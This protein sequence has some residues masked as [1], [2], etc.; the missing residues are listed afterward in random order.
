MFQN[1]KV[2]IIYYKTN[3]DFEMEFNLCG[4]CRMRLLTDKTADKK[5][6]VLSLARAVNRSRIIMIV[7]NLFGDSGIIK[8][9]SE[10]IGK[11]LTIADNATYGISGNDKIE[12]ISGSVPLVSAEGYFGGCII[13]S[14][15]QTLVLLS[16]NKTIRKSIMKNLIH[17][18][19]EELAA[20]ELKGKAEAA[21]EEK[22]TPQIIP[23]AEEISEEI[24]EEI[25]EET[26]EENQEVTEEETAEV[27]IED[28]AESLPIITDDCDE[29]NEATAETEEM[30]SLI[31]EEDEDFED[32]EMF[33]QND[34]EDDELMVDSDLIYEDATINM[35]DFITRN[36]EYY[37]EGETVKDLITDEDDDLFFQRRMNI[38][39][40]I[41]IVAVL[42]LAV[43]VVLCYC[44][45]YVPS[46]SGVTAT[47]YVN[48]IFRTLFG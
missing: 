8:L 26:V 22:T 31:A 4:C 30:E 33:S 7:G 46:K 18:Y 35:R 1:L 11:G 24:N 10:A 25:L 9:A 40:P 36:E 32:I 39:I 27:E 12:I 2:D 44:I 45:F 14:G 6:T 13:E 16:E 15:P 43:L 3:T 29:D 19:V 23:T 41:L 34:D 42:L 37:N 5:T 21:T 28:E 17:P 38:N 20:M 48:D 47:N